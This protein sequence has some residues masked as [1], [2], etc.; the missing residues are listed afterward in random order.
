[1]SGQLFLDPVGDAPLPAGCRR[2]STEV[3]WL[4]EAAAIPANELAPP[5]VVVSGRDLCAWAERWWRGRGGDCAQLQSPTAH[6][7]AACPTLGLS[8]ARAILADLGPAW[9][10]R[11]APWSLA[12]VLQELHPTFGTSADATTGWLA[13]PAT[14]AARAALAAH[15]LLWLV[16]QPQPLPR[17]HLPL[18]VQQLA[19]WADTNAAS[20]F[21]TDRAAAQAL[22]PVWLGLASPTS[23]QPDLV[24]LVGVFPVPVPAGWVAQA[25]ILH[26][27][28]LT[29]LNQTHLAA[30]EL[31]QQLTAWWQQRNKPSVLLDLRELAAT[32]YADFLLAHPQLLQP[33]H[34][35]ELLPLLGL[36]PQ[37]QA[38][39]TALP[40]A[41]PSDLPSSATP[42]AVLQ[43]A[44]AEYLPYR[45]WQASL[46]STQRQP[47]ARV[48][49]LATQFEDWLLAHY[50]ALLVSP[51]NGLLHIQQAETLRFTRTQEVTLWVVPD[52][53]G[54]LDAQTLANHI[55]AAT[56]G[57]LTPPRA[58]ACLGLLPTI[59]SLTKE[60]LLH[61]TTAR[62]LPLARPNTTRRERYIRGHLNPADH[63]R[64]VQP[65]DLF[66]W[67]PLDPD[68]A[69]HGQYDRATIQQ[70]VAYLL[71]VLAQQLA[72]AVQAIPASLALRVIVTTDHGR[73]LGSS[74]RSVAVPAGF[75]S[76]GR[77]AYATNESPS[78]VPQ[79]ADRARPELAWL[80]PEAF[81]LPCWVAAVRGDVAFRTNTTDASG[82]LHFPHGGLWPE[83]VVVPWLVAERVATAPSLTASLSGQGLARHR[84]ELALK[85]TNPSGQ[86]VTLIALSLTG[87]DGFAASLSLNGQTVPA[88]ATHKQVLTLENWPT[89]Q[90]AASLQAKLQ[91]TDVQGRPSEIANFVVQLTSEDFEEGPDLDLNF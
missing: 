12:E 48:A 75:E 69:Y 25:R 6:L 7:I 18:I 60:P 74:A 51:N 85:L 39:Q 20:L 24:K 77:A 76:H 52:G 82:Q 3:A 15:W 72:A 83:E 11:P 19:T 21:V 65:G 45:R 58:T 61:S 68:S 37:A 33:V 43:W 2:L 53:L 41:E 71:Q 31:R 73:Q 38:I 64:D 87:P 14:A 9:A 62:S 22:L 26:G 81:G 67:T 89:P 17:P 28:Q 79:T 78:V 16:D 5:A 55:H 54:W 91:L 88:T 10:A 46:P 56:A 30:D 34:L 40:P 36:A 47:A 59:T 35:R 70:R 27:Q 57:H 80:E 13:Q 4:R 63:L 84:G 44:T 1:M 8:D 23:S 86:A 32:Q 66:I 42:S 90:Q 29:A 50:P 49:T